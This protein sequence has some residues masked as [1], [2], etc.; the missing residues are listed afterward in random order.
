MCQ[1]CSAALLCSKSMNLSQYFYTR[2]NE[3][4][5]L[6]KSDV[7][8]ASIIVMQ[9]TGVAALV[10]YSQRSCLLRQKEEKAAR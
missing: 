9:A 8:L 1:E 2:V 5:S 6:R 4:T 10:L 3:S 7:E